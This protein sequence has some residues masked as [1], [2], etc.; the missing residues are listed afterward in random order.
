M[1][2]PLAHK[3]DRLRLLNSALLFAL[4]HIGLFFF[5]NESATPQRLLLS[6]AVCC[7]ALGGVTLVRRRL[8]EGPGAQDAGRS[9]GAGGR[10]ANGPGARGMAP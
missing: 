3:D 7:G 9:G 8:R 10:S 5:G 1:I 2:N 6:F 4:V